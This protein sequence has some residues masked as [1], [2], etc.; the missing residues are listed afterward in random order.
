MTDQFL[1]HKNVVDRLVKEWRQYG[2][3]II[4]YDFDDTVYDY[5]KRGSTYDN[6]LEL[7]KRC[8]KAGAHFIVFTA[9][10]EGQYR[11]ITD[12]L[13]S[14]DLPYDT[15]NKNLDFIPFTGRKVY[16]NI[17]L[18]DRAGLE[19]AYKALLEAVTIIEE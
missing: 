9:C 1:N 17:L 2:K 6:V 11:K 13:D 14:N 10:H 19:S 16:Y 3:L 4:A 12:Y 15:I 5:H 18:D 7:L 8:A